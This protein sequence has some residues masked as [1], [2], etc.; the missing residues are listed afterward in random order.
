MN[1]LLNISNPCQSILKNKYR[2]QISPIQQFS[3][4]VFGYLPT[5][6]LPALFSLIATSYFT[7]TF[8]PEEYGLYSLILA[9]TVPLST[10]FAEWIAQPATRYFADFRESGQEDRYYEALRLLLFSVGFLITITSLLVVLF[11]WLVNWQFERLTL[12]VS[13]SFVI[14]FQVLF[15]IGV[16]ILPVRLERSA[17]RNAIIIS[18]ALSVL[19]SM[20]L[21]YFWGADVL[22]LLIGSALSFLFVLP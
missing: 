10:L 12:Y 15:I 6:I 22:W 2:Y 4:D 13:A 8:L 16:R 18:S 1:P 21:V 7:R 20:F 3:K 14:F 9:Y 11:A 5:G 17:Y 19:I